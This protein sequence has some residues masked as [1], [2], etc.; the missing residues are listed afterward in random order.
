[1]RRMVFSAALAMAFT[2][3]LAVAQPANP[4]TQSLNPV[5]KMR[6]TL[7]DGQTQDVSAAESDTATFTMKDG[8]EIGVRPTILDAKP[9]T[10]VVVTFF[11]MPTTTHSTEELG[12]VEVKTA[13]AAV[14]S[15]TTPGFK[16]SVTSVGEPHVGTA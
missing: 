6:I 12:S 11:R 4:G 14:Q 16:V 2:G 5:V 15:K 8:T 1:M 13:G 10:R 7:P 3:A 9:W